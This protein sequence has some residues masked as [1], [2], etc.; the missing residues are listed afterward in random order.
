METPAVC[1]P[2]RLPRAQ[3]EEAADLAAKINPVNRPPIHRLTRIMPGF[4][5]TKARLA[6]LT[7]KY[8]GPKG[9]R[10]TV[11]F[12][13]NPSAELRK[14]ILLHMNTWAKTA[15]VTFVPARTDPQVRIARTPGDG[16]WSYLGTDI[17]LIKK[18]EPTMNL[19][20]FTMS[21]AESEYKR[22]V[23]HETGH[24]LGFPHEHMRKQ[25]VAKIH[26]QKA[27]AYFGKHYGWSPEDVRLQVLTP[28]E[29]SS[30]IGTASADA[31]SIMCYQL[32]GEITKD[33]KPILGGTD[34][35][36]WDYEFISL[37]YP[38]PKKAPR[39][40]AQQRTRTAKRRSPARTKAVKKTAAR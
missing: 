5:P 9:V 7:T 29:T 34:I 4:V 31:R 11:G 38:R 2:K 15:N 20:S 32:P 18:G 1:I 14:R 3:W 10:L 16:H 35:D 28:L 25:L 37:I 13:D 6:V 39:S 22:V 33:G 21:T 17:R 19:D 12:L 36:A 23:R 30:L 24:T 8:W 26:V 27:I 40:R